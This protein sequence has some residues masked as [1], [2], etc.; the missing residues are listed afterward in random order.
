MKERGKEREGKGKGE[1][2]EE[3]KRE[4][5]REGGRMYLNFYHFLKAL[6]FGKFECL[7]W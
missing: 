6:A 7:M 2:E 5:E 1:R 4:K 3:R